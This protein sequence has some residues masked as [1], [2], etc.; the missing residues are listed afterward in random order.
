MDESNATRKTDRQIGHLI[1][2]RYSLIYVVSFEEAR[3]EKSLE[4]IASSFSRKQGAEGDFLCV[5]WSVTDGFKGLPSGVSSDIR[6]PLG[7]LQ[8]I[9]EADQQGLFILRDFHPFL[10]DAG[11]I[12]KLR[13][14]ARGLYKARRYKSVIL[15][16]PILKV[17]PEL[18]KDLAIIDY[19]LPGREEIERTLVKLNRAARKSDRRIEED[20]DYRERVV[21]AAMGLTAMEAENVF[22]KSII[23]RKS[24]DIGVILSE[25][26]Q[27][28]RKSQVLEYFHSREDFDGVGGLD[29]LKEW[30]RKRQLAF[31]EKA[32][33]FGLPL[34]KGI[35]LIGIPGCGK[36]LTAKAVANLW[37]MPLL[38]L[39]MGKVFAGIVGSSEENMRNAI[40]LSESIAPCI[41]WIDELEKGFSGTQSSAYS[42]AGTAARVFGS[43]ITWMQEKSH[44][45]FVIATA[46]DVSLL[47]PEFLRKGRFDEIFFVDLPTHPEREEIFRIHLEKRGREPARFDLSRLARASENYSGSEIEQAVIS[48]L[49]DAFDQEEVGDIETSGVLRS[50][51]ETIPLSQTMERELRELRVWART[52]ARGATLPAVTAEE[53]KGAGG[54]EEEGR[55]LDL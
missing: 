12:R 4:R 5:K 38:R 50:L 9:E 3:V 19:D 53:G 11:V 37:R 25:K 29:I 13:D 49:Y 43:F 6:D 18:E 36:S 52:R 44:P 27:I 14:L 46:N 1:Q 35:L 34:P 41:L 20:P 54:E 26:E 2:A 39:D 48:A 8:L 42:D 33:E 51:Q 22:S 24:I 10:G 23:E 30:L 16:S 40:K 55:R 7:A 21:K 28:I 31:T 32:R 47:P 17:P 15:L 45:V